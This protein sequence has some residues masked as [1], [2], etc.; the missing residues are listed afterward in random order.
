[1]KVG[2]G[3]RRTCDRFKLGDEPADKE[4]GMATNRNRRRRARWERRRDQT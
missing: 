1:M 2:E 4:N 3:S